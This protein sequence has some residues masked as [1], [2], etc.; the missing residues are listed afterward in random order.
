MLVSEFQGIISEA[1]GGPGSPG[2]SGT[3]GASFAEMVAAI[4]NAEADNREDTAGAQEEKRTVILGRDIMTDILFIQEHGLK[5]YAEQLNIQKME[6]MRKEILEKMGLTQE[7]LDAMPSEQRQKIEDMI[8]AEI[9]AYLSA[10]NTLEAMQE[11]ATD[12]GLNHALNHDAAVQAANVTQTTSTAVTGQT[13]G[14]Q[15]K[16]GPAFLEALEAEQKLDQDRRAPGQELPH[17][18]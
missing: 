4:R 3:E 10:E 14:G 17:S 5:T 6:E 16:I 2:K 9:A 13:T 12:T 18:G 8:D 11:Q 7:D 15:V 1:R